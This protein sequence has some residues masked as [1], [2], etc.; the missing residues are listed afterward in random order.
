V[1]VIAHRGGGS[2]GAENSIGA[3]ESSL[4]AGADGV[5]IDVRLSAD[6]TVVLLHD[7]DVGR[8]TSGHGRVAEMTFDELRSL[9]V[10][11]LAEVLERVP[12]DRLLIVELKGHPWEAGHDP[13]E[14][15]A[16]AVAA[17]VSGAARRLVVSS[18]NPMAL[19]VIRERA[20]G[21]PTALLTSA[22]FDLA[23]NLAAVVAGGHDECHVPAD[24]VDAVFVT[25][26]HA[27]G[28]RVVA[29]TVNDPEQI[30]G[31]AADGVDG[32]ITDDPRGARAALGEQRE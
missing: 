8:T 3:I 30:R 32:I 1:N 13:S 9:G 23:S 28:K 31:C 7:P 4:A 17:I 27:A 18:F 19:H 2:F 24:L 14:P 15:L 5:E 21:V 11:S 10:P 20:A 25:A 26:A 12:A 16:H 29:W 6:G 22:A